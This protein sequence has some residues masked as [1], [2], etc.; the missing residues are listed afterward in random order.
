MELFGYLRGNTLNVNNFLH[1]TGFGDFLI[2]DVEQYEDPV[3]IQNAQGLNLSVHQTKKNSRKNSANNNN[4]MQMEVEKKTKSGKEIDD[5]IENE[6]NLNDLTNKPGLIGN[7]Q[8]LEN[9]Q[10]K[11]EK[12]NINKINNG[13]D[14]LDELIDF[15]INIPDDG[16][17]ISFEEDE[18]DGIQNDKKMSNKHKDKTTLGYRTYDEMEFPDEVNFN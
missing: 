9:I 1:I 10:K 18:E 4:D 6:N 13:I 2:S 7:E 11:N 15:D 12:E 14:E 8:I 5:K 17:D 3:P 16:N